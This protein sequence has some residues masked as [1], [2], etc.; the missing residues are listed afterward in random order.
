MT[1]NIKIHDGIVG[2]LILFSVL[3]AWR[4]DLRWLALTA[5][6]A[7][8]MISSSFTGFCPVHF[9]VNKLVRS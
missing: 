5:V 2:S 1:K 3:M 4:I 9:V 6:T 7:M 8:I